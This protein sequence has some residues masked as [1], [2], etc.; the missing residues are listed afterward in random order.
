MDILFPGVIPG[1]CSPQL[2]QRHFYSCLHV[3]PSCG[4]FSRPKSIEVRVVFCCTLMGSK[5]GIVTIFWQK[6]LHNFSNHSSRDM[7]KWAVQCPI[8]TCLAVHLTSCGVAVG[9]RGGVERTER[10]QMHHLLWLLIQTPS[11]ALAPEARVRSV[12]ACPSCHR[13][14]EMCGL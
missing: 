11:A 9:Q 14:S 6:C 10:L 2:Y 4:A 7:E 13:T 3:P 1:N 12:R 8:C 5:F